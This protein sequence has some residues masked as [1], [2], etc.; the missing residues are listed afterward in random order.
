MEQVDFKAYSDFHRILFTYIRSIGYID[1]E[2][3]LERSK[4]ILKRLFDD[5][6][7]EG[8]DGNDVAKQNLVQSIDTINI[9]IGKHGFRIEK[10]MHEVLG[11]IN[12][13]FINTIND[14]M[15][16]NRSFTAYSK[17]EVLMIKVIIDQI[18]LHDFNLSINR[19]FSKLSGDFPSKNVKDIQFLMKQ[20]IN[21]GWFILSLDDR[22]ILSPKIMAELKGYFEK[23]DPIICQGCHNIVSLGCKYDNKPFHH[24]CFHIYQRSNNIPHNPSEIIGVDLNMIKS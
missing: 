13:T 11:D 16:F 22:L 20:L 15:D 1:E 21:D 3:L 6:G 17:Q 4:L 8:D 18:F 9:N 12:Y 10:I 24:K 7:D 5:E 14:E 19:V 2:T 23:F